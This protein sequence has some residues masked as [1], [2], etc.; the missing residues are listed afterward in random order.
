MR[1]QACDKLL[2]DFE[3]TRKSATYEDYLDLCNECYNSIRADV[4]A[5]ERTDLMSIDEELDSDEDVW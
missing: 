3:S 1:C 5:I 2:T 4:K